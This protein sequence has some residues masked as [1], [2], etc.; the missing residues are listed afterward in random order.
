M[1]RDEY[2]GNGGWKEW[3]QY[4]KQGIK[5]LKNAV[6]DSQ[7]DLVNMK[8]ELGMLK[9]KMAVWGAI[10]ATIATVLLQLLFSYLKLKGGP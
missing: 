6:S 5:E 1:P 2:D 7:K 9:A 10:G 3:S 4:V 8:V